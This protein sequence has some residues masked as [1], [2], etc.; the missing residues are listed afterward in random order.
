M[1]KIFFILIGYGRWSNIYL[2]VLSKFVNKKYIFVYSKTNFLNLKKNK[3]LYDENKIQN[4][5]HSVFSKKGSVIILLNKN[6]LRKKFLTL[7]LKNNLHCIYEKPYLGGLKE[8]KKLLK[9]F[10]KKKLKFMISIPWSFNNILNKI[11]KKHFILYDRVSIKWLETKNQ[12]KYGLLKRRNIKI[13]YYK[14][15]ISHIISI[16][17]NFTNTP[18]SINF[19][20]DFKKLPLNKKA[21]QL[22]LSR[23]SKFNKREFKFY[24]SNKVFMELNLGSKISLLKNKQILLSQYDDKKD[25]DRMLIYFVKKKYLQIYNEYSGL[26]KLIA[27]LTKK[28]NLNLKA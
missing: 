27:Y 4:T 20:K 26:F 2:R 11:K 1:K 6:N 9:N 12:K 19:K 23:N 24:K 18:L 7:A 10:K 14:D 28:N 13:S 22:F 21:M 25:L 8:V 5:N 3:F 17:A 15:I 16:L